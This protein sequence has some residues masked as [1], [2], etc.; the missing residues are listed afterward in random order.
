MT[1]S[2]RQQNKHVQI[3][4]KESNNEFYRAVTTRTDTVKF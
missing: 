3:Q 1:E 4:L 2:N